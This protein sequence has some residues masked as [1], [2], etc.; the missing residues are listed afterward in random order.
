MTNNAAGG[1]GNDIAIDDITFRPYGSQVS[2]VFSSA[3]TTE[4][5]CAGGTSQNITVNVTTALASGYEQKLQEYIN[6]T[7]TDESAASTAT[8]FT[9]ASPTIAGT[10]LYR[11]VSGLTSNIS[12]SE[13]VVS[14][15]EL[16]LTIN[17]VPSA[18]FTSSST[19]CLGDSTVFK[20]ASTSTLSITSWLWNF[21]DGQTSTQ[22]NPSH[23]Y[24]ASGTYSVTLT[25]TNSGGCSSTSA[26]QTITINAAAIASFTYSSPACT[27]QPVVFTDASTSTSGSIAKWIWNY[28]D[29]STDTLL[30]NA[31]HTHTYT[32]AGAYTATLKV[33]TS[34]G[35]ASNLV[36][37]SI[38]VNPLPVADF[39]MPDVCLSDAYAQFTDESTIA[40]NTQSS[41]TY[42]WNFGDTN[43][44]TSN[45]NT[46]TD[47][48]P[49]HKYST[50]GNYTV[51]LTVTSKYGC[52]S[53]T[54]SQLFTVNGAVPEASFTVL[55]AGS[56][57]SS[58]N[59]E[60]DNSSTVDFGSITKIIFYYDYI[61]APADSNVF[62][63]NLS[64]IPA[65]GKFYHNYGTFNTP[66]TKNYQVKMVVY[67][68][69]TCFSTSDYTIT[70]NANPIVTLSVIGSLCQNAAA[71]QITEDKNGFT[72]TGV[73]SGTGVS[74]SGLFDPSVSGAGTFNIS[75][76][77]TAQTGCT[78]SA[79]QSITVYATP[80]ITLPS[81]YYILSGGQ[82]TLEAKATG[83]SLTYKWT[84]A[85]GL[86]DV[87]I[88]NPIA[89]PTT[90]T[91]YQLTVTSAHGC[92]A[93]AMVSVY[94]LQAPV[95]PN[96]F[97]PN[98]DG[99]NDTWDIK[100]LDSYPDCTVSIFNRYGQRL[101]YSVGYPVAWDGKY[102]GSPLPV[103]VYYY[104]INPKHGR[105]PISGSLTLLR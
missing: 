98:G 48:N 104:I 81:S 64:Q 94:V 14:S 33:I 1:I 83:D 68:G 52:V 21:G 37:Q 105:G 10:Y 59:V 62:Y 28:G 61:N 35:C 42:L 69:E 50:V 16:T 71:V 36:S 101:F 29:N 47:E 60:F 78:Y 79:S 75:Y 92:T 57:C 96:A 8:S 67:S 44:T 26:I 63:K 54:K 41:F 18:A 103:G 5:L 4:S 46:S 56:L 77:F 66:V 11:V 93:S 99:I 40:D 76:L 74:S 70:V 72:G 85:T 95:V 43:A 32:T 102:N 87:T 45:P 13:C 90:D 80:V 49:K 55:N 34:A 17:P 82:T 15:N 27:G 12:S 24:T 58:D 3:A 25:A 31:T 84:P 30:T 6:G 86:S 91:Q 19:D 89:S 100:Y 38:V 73:F 88:L 53:A 9:F 7:W 22:Q 23:L 39:S 51:T 65:D 2:T 20:D 97:T